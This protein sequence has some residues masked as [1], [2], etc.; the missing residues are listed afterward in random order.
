MDKLQHI[1]DLLRKASQ[2]PANALV[3]DSDWK[4]VERKLE[5]RKIRIYA[6]W[7]FL[8]LITFSVS[9]GTL[10]HFNT[11]TNEQMAQ[12]TTESNSQNQNDISTTTELPVVESKIKEEMS[13]ENDLVDI[14]PTDRILSETETPLQ[15]QLQGGNTPVEN[16]YIPV[17]DNPSTLP[18]EIKS[19]LVSKQ[20]P[21][22]L[23]LDNLELELIESPYLAN[24]VLKTPKLNDKKK[25]TNK[26]GGTP[27]NSKS[28][29]EVGLAFTPSISNKIV[30]E[31]SALAGLINRDYY[32]FVGDHEGASFSN[33]YGIN[34]QFHAPRK[35]YIATGLFVSQ[36]TESV[37]YNY[38]NKFGV[39][40]NITGTS[41][42]SYYIVN[43]T[44][45]DTV[46][47][48]G[49]NSYHFIEIP[50]NFG[51]KLP[52]SSN[53]ELR[54]QV[55]ISYLQLVQRKGKTGDSYNL[56]LKDLNELD[57]N[58]HNVAANIK[59]GVYYNT[60][61]FAIG[62]E[63]TFGMN[64]NSLSSKS[65]SIQTKPYSYGLNLTTNFKLIK[66]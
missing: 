50:I 61:R 24:L 12:K 21:R 58:T 31:N 46:K 42:D 25:G 36:R 16:D 62:L 40:K 51:Y 15:I 9:V 44:K 33:S 20:V 6:M 41:I 5:H 34:L 48:K 22:L 57:L 10:M 66:K 54:S 35:F 28:H 32:N 13:N 47:Y 55:G 63:P 23:N 49:S 52:I 64:I 7:I 65:S 4:A 45:Y 3:N 60:S 43:P 19:P 56:S 39:S 29:I 38:I 18:T 14:S 30:S 53:F 8:A 17:I 2:V 59:S 27:P 37:N 26:Q 1:D 11:P